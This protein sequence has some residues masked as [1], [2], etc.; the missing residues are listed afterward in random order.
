MTFKRMIPT[1]TLMWLWL[2]APFF[3]HIIIFNNSFY[4]IGKL[5]NKIV[6]IDWLVP[7]LLMLGVPCFSF[8]FYFYLYV[9][10]KK[11]ELNITYLAL[12][13]FSFLSLLIFG[14]IMLIGL[15]YQ[16]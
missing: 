5:L 1:F 13:S 9:K 2:S 8:I 11:S 10:E 4:F 15:N 12:A 14:V 7:M 6:P 3:S 16:N